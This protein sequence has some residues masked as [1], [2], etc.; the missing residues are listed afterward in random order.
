MST[1]SAEYRRAVEEERE[2]EAVQTAQAAAS[3]TQKRND[4][5]T[6]SEIE[7]RRVERKH[8]AVKAYMFTRLTEQFA[9]KTRPSI[10]KQRQE[11]QAAKSR[12]S[13]TRLVVPAGQSGKEDWTEETVA[14]VSAQWE[15]SKRR[16]SKAKSQIRW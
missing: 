8:K 2:Q 13:R 12:G 1:S 7:K 11:R 10:A 4:K 5:M 15:D 14:G 3:S 16:G 9:S 6:P